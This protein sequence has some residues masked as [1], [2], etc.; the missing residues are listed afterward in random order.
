MESAPVAVC[1]GGLGQVRA[2]ARYARA[3]RLLR[4]LSIKIEEHSVK[5]NIMQKTDAIEAYTVSL[6]RHHDRFLLLQRSLQK[7]FAPGR[8]TGLGGRVEMGEF[9]QLRASA[10]REVQE[11]AGLDPQQISDFVFRRALLVSRPNQA[12]NVILYYTGVL[13]QI[14]T[15]DCPEGTLYWKQEA[16]FEELDIIETTRPVLTLLVQD[17][18]IDPD[19]SDLPKIGIAVFDKK[20]IFVRDLWAD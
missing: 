9:T 6:L 5:G 7:S 10:L 11:E 4:G 17:M 12:L 14:S 20:G 18:D 13:T 16:E 8:W 1:V 19:G 15:P 3:N 2:G